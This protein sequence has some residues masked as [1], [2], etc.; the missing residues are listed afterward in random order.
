VNHQQLESLE[1]G[2]P[3]QV[4]EKLLIDR[5]IIGIYLGWIVYENEKKVLATRDVSKVLRYI[6]SSQIFDGMEK[7]SLLTRS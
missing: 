4:T 6:H 5:I 1:L 7:L 3:L 2:K